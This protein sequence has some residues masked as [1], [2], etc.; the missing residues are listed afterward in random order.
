LIN[1]HDL[2]C[3]VLRVQGTIFQSGT[4]LNKD[5]P[6]RKRSVPIPYIR[7]SKCSRALSGG[8]GERV[9]PVPIPNT[10]VKP[11]SADGTWRETARESRTLPDQF[12]QGHTSDRRSFLLKYVPDIVL[13]SS[14]AEHSA[15][16]RRVTGSSPVWGAIH[17]RQIMIVIWRFRF[18]RVIFAETERIYTWFVVK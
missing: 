8:D 2:H 12:V 4:F 14:M 15:V 5:D 18:W 3:V 16:N 11:F 13:S 10:E 1:K 6:Q 17:K 9:T 7:L